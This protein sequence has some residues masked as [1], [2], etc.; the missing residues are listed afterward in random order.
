[1]MLLSEDLLRLVALP[2]ICLELEEAE[3][4]FRG[5]LISNIKSSGE[6]I[7]FFQLLF[8]TKSSI[9]KE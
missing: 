1:M 8:Y 4:S 6:F 3:T 2:G 7:A 5:G 9:R